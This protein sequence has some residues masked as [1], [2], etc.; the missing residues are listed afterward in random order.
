MWDEAKHMEGYEKEAALKEM[1][2]N[3]EVRNRL[4]KWKDFMKVACVVNPN[5]YNGAYERRSCQRK[6]R[7]IGHDNFDEPFRSEKSAE[8]Y[9]YG[10]IY[11]SVDFNGATYTIKETGG[12]I[13]MVYF[14]VVTGNK[15]DEVLSKWYDAR[16]INKERHS[17]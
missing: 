13:G 1:H 15:Y 10:N 5:L 8:P 3:P 6:L 7:Y 9:I 2:N 12:I 17:K 11:H 16:H 4:Y 14:E